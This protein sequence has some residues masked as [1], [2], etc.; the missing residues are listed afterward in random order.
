MASPRLEHNDAGT[1]LGYRELFEH[2]NGAQ[3]PEWQRNI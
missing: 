1:R 3:G 2:V